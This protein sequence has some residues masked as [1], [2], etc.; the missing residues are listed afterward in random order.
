MDYSLPGSSVPGIFPARIL[1]LVA[2]PFSKG[3][4]ETRKQTQVF[5]IVGGFIFYGVS[6]KV[7]QLKIYKR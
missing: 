6:Y 4:S 3:S 5:C 1:E 2:I 7:A